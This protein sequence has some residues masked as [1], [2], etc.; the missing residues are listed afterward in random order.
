V[1]LTITGPQGLE[2]TFSCPTVTDSSGNVEQASAL[3]IQCGSDPPIITFT[4]APQTV[5]I[6]IQTTGTALGRLF[7][8]ARPRGRLYAS[9]FAPPWIMLPLVI[10]GAG[11]ARRPRPFRQARLR[12]A[13]LSVAIGLLASCGGGFSLPK[14]RLTT[15]AG[16]Y[17]LTIVDEPLGSS[18]GFVQTSLIVPLT[19]A[20]FQ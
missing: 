13:A 12:L 16:S 7:P 5:T 3:G 6:G 11:A 9:W 19:V 15:P 18:P 8:S 14:A 20:P 1:A 2:V 10:L 4:G 17:Q